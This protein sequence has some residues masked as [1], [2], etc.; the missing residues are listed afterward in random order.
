MSRSSCESE[1]WS[2]QR[3]RVEIRRETKVQT[4]MQSVYERQCLTRGQYV[5]HGGPKKVISFDHAH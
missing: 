4:I 3:V 2:K 1:W 5:R